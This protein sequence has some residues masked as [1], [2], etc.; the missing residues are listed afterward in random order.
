VRLKGEM[1]EACIG[2]EPKGWAYVTALIKDGR[3]TGVYID[4]PH[5]QVA[6]ARP[7]VVGSSFS[8]TSLFK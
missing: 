4:E 7:V 5:P 3:A 6:E 8:L 1:S 2:L